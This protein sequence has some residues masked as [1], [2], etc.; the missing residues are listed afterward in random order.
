MWGIKINRFIALAVAFL[1]FTLNPSPGTASEVFVQPGGSIQAVINN[2]SSGDEIVI[3]SGNYTENIVITKD[4]LVIRSGSGNPENTTIIAGNSSI[5]VLRIRANNT[6]VSGFKIRAA[7]DADVAGIYLAGCT[8]CTIDNNDVSENYLGIYL[9]NSKNN[10]ILSNRVNSNERYGI[11][12]VR[13]ESNLLLNNTAD[14]NNHGIVVENNCSNNNLTGNLADSN[15]DYGFYL[16]NSSGNTL[17]NNTAT[18]NNMGIHL[19]NSN[20]SVISGNNVFRNF[21]YGI[22]MSI[23]NYSTISGNNVNKTNYGI[24]LDSSDNNILYGNVIASNYALGLSMCG[25]CDSNTVFNNY[26]NNNL[27][28]D[29]K[30]R[31]NALN[32]KKTEGTNIVG[33]PYIAGNF[34]ASPGGT[35]FSETA[36]DGDG[37]GIAD[38]VYNETNVTDYLP[39]VS[40]S[41]SQQQVLPVTDLNVSVNITK[42]NP[43]ISEEVSTPAKN[44]SISDASQI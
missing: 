44:N 14:S 3:G 19:R 25:A 31:K 34:W 35:G 29:I 41:S 26:F 43:P 20:K 6:T 12:L 40:E 33:G 23:S 16:I 2:A 4:D 18:E 36:P 24:H 37:N 15:L 27:N 17:N 11:Q 32:I 42:F 13:S 38:V 5:D 8:N 9:S 30:N 28:T 39:L 7:E 22:W 21:N 1:I 10:T